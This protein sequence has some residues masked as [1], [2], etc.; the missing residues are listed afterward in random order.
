VFRG[1]DVIWPVSLYFAGFLVFFRWQLLS[2]FDLVFGDR[3]DAR[4]VAFL[5]EHI[6][7]W[8]HGEGAFLSPPFFFDQTDTLG[9]S[10]AFLLDQIIYA[11]LRLLGAEPLLA[12]SLIAVITSA[13]AFGFLYLLLRRLDIS[14]PVAAVAAL[15]ATFPN[16]LYLKSG[17]LQHF[18]VYYIPLVA[19]CAL[20]A[21]TDLHRRPLRAYAL[22][23]LA[24]ALY[25]ILFSTGYY[26]TWF[27]GF[28]LLIFVPIAGWVAWP[29]VS[30]WWR[31]SP[32]RVCLLATAAALGFAAALSIFVVI[33][34]P[35]LVTGAGRDFGEYL[36]Y[37]PRPYD[38]LN[39]GM[40]NLV[41]SKLIRALPFIHL[42]HLGN[43]E[44]WIAMTPMLQI[45]LVASAVLAWRPQFWPRNAAGRRSRAFVIGGACV[46]FLFFIF[47]VSV[48]DFSLFRV[49]YA[50]VPGANAIRAGY[51]GMIIA[52]LFAVTAVGLT[53]DRLIRLS[54]QRA[55]G[56]RR[57]VSL[58]GLS[59]LLAL[60]AV[61]QINLV[62]PAGL[63]R[64]FEH[65]HFSG[66][67]VAPRACR[68]F[69]VAAQA[70]RPPA[71]VQVD[72]MMIAQAEHLPTING[73][74]GLFPPDWHL[75]DTTKPD[76]EEN[77]ARWAVTR[78]IAQGLCRV[79]V[80]KKSW[81]V[82]DVDKLAP[83]RN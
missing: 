51:R 26:M 55:P 47:I 7:R 69:Y 33:Y 83:L 12:L 81:S 32:Q 38:V 13:A 17:H 56:L 3:G 39:V 24:A 66:L 22:A 64:E 28:A 41:W 45:L 48:G 61:E 71:A 10:D 63:S 1:R 65:Q 68:T 35:V 49:L 25:G 9:W 54:L 36:I 75:Y 40:E 67:A 43:G 14:V 15:V 52:N 31:T 76:Y 82:V 72:G 73:S 80:D 77:A 70:G 5:H 74:S 2:K 29:E 6:Y 57:A 78:G 62:Q 58:T 23:A 11:P 44:L 50:V 34:G 53:F 30:A 21:V 79:D 8:F 27:F 20:L 42:D 18:T 37:S 60:T 19:F 4:F 16:N 59:A 46:C